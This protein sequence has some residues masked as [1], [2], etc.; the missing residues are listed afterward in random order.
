MSKKIIW[1]LSLCLMLM[2]VVLIKAPCADYFFGES[3]KINLLELRAKAD[4]MIYRLNEEEVS[5]TIYLT[6]VSEEPLEIVEPAVDRRSFFIEVIDPMGKKDNLS[7]IY[8]LKLKNIRLLAGKRIKFTAAFN[9][10][11]LGE[12]VIKV[13]YNGY[14]EVSVYAEP[15]SVYIVRA[16]QKNN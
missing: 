6:N 12:H 9:P 15:V 5:L 7:V 10:E 16:A 3:D 8:G 2:S 13:S 4:K 11:S 1:S 14:G